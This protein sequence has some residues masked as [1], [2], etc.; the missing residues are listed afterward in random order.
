MLSL[1]ES[2]EVRDRTGCQFNAI[3]FDRK[4]RR[5]KV[6]VGRGL[7]VDDVV[8]VVVIVA[9]VFLVAGRDINFK[10]SVTEAICSM[11]GAIRR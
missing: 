7:D 8:V 4:N 2:L 1:N 9:V 5:P 10:E 6:R 3:I 11:R